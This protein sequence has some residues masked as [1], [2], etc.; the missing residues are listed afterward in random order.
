MIYPDYISDDVI[1]R[2]IAENGSVQSVEKMLKM[3]KTER[4]KIYDFIEQN[5]SKE[6]MDLW[7]DKAEMIE[8][9]NRSIYQAMED[10]YLKL[11]NCVTE[12][13]GE[14]SQEYKDID[15][16][17]EIDIPPNYS[18]D[19]ILRGITRIYSVIKLKELMNE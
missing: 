9:E 4:Q 3:T 19:R 13:F 16:L 6:H 12:L 14:G 18:R 5:C 8:F 7:F 2:A 10:K 15:N 11:M 1:S 17:A